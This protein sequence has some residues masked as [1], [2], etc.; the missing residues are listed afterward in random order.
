MSSVMLVGSRDV[1]THLDKVPINKPHS[2]PANNLIA[3]MTNMLQEVHTWHLGG[4]YT[5]PV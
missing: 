2:H 5:C 1:P 3:H 4:N